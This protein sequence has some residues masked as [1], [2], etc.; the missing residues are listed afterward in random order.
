MDSTFWATGYDGMWNA[1]F[2][3]PRKRVHDL[4]RRFWE[5]GVVWGGIVEN[6]H[7]VRVL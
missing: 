2:L 6:P 4:P 3:Q 7:Q 1:E 5:P